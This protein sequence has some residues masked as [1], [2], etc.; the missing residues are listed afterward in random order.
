MSTIDPPTKLGR[1]KKRPRLIPKEEAEQ[2]L[3]EVYDEFKL[4]EQALE[5]L[6]TLITF[7][8][9]SLRNASRL[10]GKGESLPCPSQLRASKLIMDF[11]NDVRVFRSK[12]VDDILNSVKLNMS[13]QVTAVMDKDL[14]A[15]S[16]PKLTLGHI[17]DI[18]K[19]WDKEQISARIQSTLFP[20]TM[21]EIWHSLA[22]RKREQQ[23]MLY[24]FHH[25]V[26]AIIESSHPELSKLTIKT[27]GCFEGED[28]LGR[29]LR[30]YDRASGKL[31][32]SH[33][34]S[35]IESMLL[36]KLCKC[37]DLSKISEDDQA[38]AKGIIYV[39]PCPMLLTLRENIMKIPCI[40]SAKPKKVKSSVN[41]AGA[42][43]MN[44]DN[45][46]SPSTKPVV[47][48]E[49]SKKR[50]REEENKGDYDVEDTLE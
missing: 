7:I 40:A 39:G 5:R 29:L 14:P 34:T 25:S 11:E 3:T 31:N 46:T 22:S 9:N 38:A 24:E 35:I 48:S 32:K 6:T 18:W 20:S 2:L 33:A 36:C 50:M 23:L 37:V 47:K 44:F 19:S 15:F 21:R 8:N 12:K 28:A 42:N 26:T 45:G 1:T 41:E 13:Y 27:E 16:K 43:N 49:E 17:T 30:A 4:L 10:C